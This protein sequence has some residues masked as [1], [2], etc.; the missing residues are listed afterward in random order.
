[1]KRKNL[2]RFINRKA[3]LVA[4][5]IAL[6]FCMT[7]IS[8]GPLEEE[9][10]VTAITLNKSGVTTIA[11]GDVDYI[12]ITD[13][14]DTSSYNVA[15]T[16]SNTAVVDFVEKKGG[17]CIIKTGTS[18][19]QSTATVTATIGKIS[20][21]CSYKVE[22]QSGKQVTGVSLRE[23]TTA[24]TVGGTKTIAYT[25]EPE[26]ANQD[27]YW[28]SS[29]PSVAKVNGD[30]GR[31]TAVGT[32]TADIT[33]TTKN[34][35]LTDKCNV[36]VSGSGSGGGGGNNTILVE[37]IEIDKD[38]LTLGIDGTADLVVKVLP[39]NATNKTVTWTSDKTNIATV[40]TNGKVTA[41]AGGTA[42]ITATTVD[43][44]YLVTCAVT[45]NAA[46]DLKLD[47]TSLYIPKGITVLITATVS[48][49]TAT[50]SWASNNTSVATVN[51]SETGIGGSV[52]ANAVGTATITVTGSNNKT[53]T[54]S[55][56]VYD[57]GNSTAYYGSYS[58]TYNASA[59]K[60]VI[61]TIK[62]ENGLITISDNDHAVGVQPDFLELT[63]D[64]WEAAEAPTAY[65]TNYPIAYKITGKITNAQPKT[66]TPYGN[67]TAAGFTP[68]DITNNTTCWM[69][70]YISYS[71][72]IL[73]TPLSKS[74]KDNGTAPVPFTST[75]KTI[76]VYSRVT[77]P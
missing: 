28:T 3:I 45:V 50:L 5:L 57:P 77:T 68:S 65:K 23:K 12:Y 8:C 19:T 22:D 51:A 52:A 58:G 49:S 76:R 10:G 66:G 59:T 70:I 20:K 33:V 2:Y 43:G 72:D 35:K 24:M 30:S 53:A 32:G 7:F 44:G 27:V 1:M 41:K 73:R 18:V 54:C 4:G 38:K 64:K 34:K 42:T 29:D 63:V 61:E 11:L 62:I 74:G 9:E 25:V 31:I 48:P 39:A 40:D 16:T 47:K 67:L 6:V 60:K 17:Y 37:S 46:E 15:W 71:G 13:P 56:T 69:Y 21:S 75:D 26:A 55:V 14:A 36:T